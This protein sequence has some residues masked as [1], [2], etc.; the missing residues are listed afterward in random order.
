MMRHFERALLDELA[1]KAAASPRKRAHYNIHPHADDPVQ[2]FLVVAQRDSYFRPHR[3]A[4]KSELALVLR[5]RFDVVT[6]DE[7]GVVTGRSTVGDGTPLMAFEIPEAT[8]HTLVATSDGSSFLEV[9]QG[10]SDPTTA[11]ELAP[12]SPAEGDEAVPAYLQW[13]RVAQAGARS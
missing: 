13:L 11:A 6:F 8:W 3:H 4:S 5:G 12:W 9:K 7:Q 1:A 10:P 2:R